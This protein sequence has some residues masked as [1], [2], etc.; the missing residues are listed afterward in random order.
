MTRTE[1]L[2]FSGLP[3]GR[4]PSGAGVLTRHTALASPLPDAFLLP[5]SQEKNLSP[6]RRAWCR[7]LLKESSPE[8]FYAGLWNLG[9][10]L[11]ADEAPTQAALIYRHILETL[12]AAG[13]PWERSLRDAVGR[14]ATA[15]SGAGPLAGQ[16]EGLGRRFIRETAQPLPILAF[17]A[18]SLAFRSARLLTFSRLAASPEASWLTRGSGLRALAGLSGWAAESLAYPLVLHAGQDASFAERWAQGAIL[19]GSLRLTGWA[20]SVA[21]PSASGLSKPALDFAGNFSGILLGQGL[22]AKISGA[23]ASA[24]PFASGFMTFLQMKI[25]GRVAEGVLGPGFARWERSLDAGM[26]A[27]Q[28]P[29]ASGWR[30]APAW[31]GTDALPG[32]GETL[33]APILMMSV[34][35]TELHP[36]RPVASS[37][38]SS[39]GMAIVQRESR[40]RAGSLRVELRSTKDLTEIEWERRLRS[41]DDTVSS[42]LFGYIPKS[43]RLNG[44]LAKVLSGNKDLGKELV[45][46]LE[47]KG[48]R[49]VAQVDFDARILNR[50]IVLNADG[51]P[52][53]LFLAGP[54]GTYA[55]RLDLNFLREDL[56]FLIGRKYSFSDE[57]SPPQEINL[58][59]VSY[60]GI[61]QA[62]TFNP[63]TEK[64]LMAS[65][66]WRIELAPMG[67]SAAAS[68]HGL[69]F[70]IKRSPEHKRWRIRDARHAP[71]L[72]VNP[73]AWLEGAPSLPPWPQDILAS[74]FP[75]E[76]RN[77]ARESS[78][79]KASPAIPPPPLGDQAR[80]PRIPTP[81][82]L[83][84]LKPSKK[85]RV[86]GQVVAVP[87]P[88]APAPD[89]SGPRRT[90]TGKTEAAP[91]VSA[92]KIQEVLALLRRFSE[93]KEASE[94]QARELLETLRR[95][96]RGLL[97]KE[98]QP[99]ALEATQYVDRFFRYSQAGM[100]LLEMWLNKADSRIR[101]ELSVKVA[102]FLAHKQPRYRAWAFDL[103]RGVVQG[104]EGYE[105][106]GLKSYLETRYPKDKYSVSD[107]FMVRQVQI[108][109]EEQLKEP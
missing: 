109:I 106:N 86:P 69:I 102:D 80:S 24:S 38:V 71:L 98:F 61:P 46:H 107:R 7:E 74:D 30:R 104:L 70:E 92:A 22:A 108:L 53:T 47:K 88:P 36:T 83:P 10:A 13:R 33:R 93:G 94:T 63:L 41:L 18:A 21:R 43:N 78:R 89:A 91:E 2:V 17:G 95:E 60:N 35:E 85:L 3:E 44:P 100:P 39:Q 12:P 96:S 5:F 48:H 25:G 23:P 8:L 11:E 105:L 55:T 87:G 42:L 49:L 77:G 82:A 29:Q 57:L 90:K 76:S 45:A 40:F 28:K 50:L 75:P 66:E 72:S 34:K 32:V 26:N 54:D 84:T 31:A 4:H 58:L 97:R 9:L 20:T 52:K 64:H 14:Q 1:L 19:M 37:A 79:V 65:P 56:P 51:R 103:L 101:V 16:I 15:L 68:P 27:P 59:E 6:E 99:I 67:E 81:P 62:E 73:D